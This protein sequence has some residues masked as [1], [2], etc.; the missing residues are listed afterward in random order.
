MRLFPLK[1]NEINVRDP[2]VLLHDNVYYLYGTRSQTCWGPAD[3]FDCYTSRDLENWDGPFEIFHRP[4][5]FFADRCYWAPECYE[6][7]GKFYLITTLGCEDRKKGIYVLCS[8]SPLGPFVPTGDQPL[9]PPDWTCI[10]GSLFWDE[11]GTP[12]LLFSHAFEDDPRGAMCALELTSDL[13][14]AADE[15]ITL[16]YAGEAPWATPVPFAKAEFGMDGD[17]YFTDGP[18]AFRQNDGS[19]LL[20]W[21]SWSDCGY[22]VGAAVSKSGGINGP[23]EQL[24]EK[25]FPGNGGHGMLFQTIEGKSL[26]T[27]HYPNDFGKEHPVFLPVCQE[28]GTLRLIWRGEE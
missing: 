25:V 28:D 27:L 2:Y 8:D 19:I 11:H 1:T 4:D 9:T 24:P 12:Y 16:F 17:V 3:G 15:P 5:G 23:W 6:F 13:L 26:Y 20:L 14:N 10:D 7:E 22:G 21:A 18:C